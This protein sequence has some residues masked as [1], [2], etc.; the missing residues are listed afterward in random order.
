MKSDLS[1]GSITEQQIADYVAYERV[2]ASSKYN[3]FDP[4]AM[5]ASGLDQEAYLFVMKNYDAL[6]QAHHERSG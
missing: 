3:M 5:A 2:R 6:R 4:R 1:S